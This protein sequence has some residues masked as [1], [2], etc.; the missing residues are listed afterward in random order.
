MSLLKSSKRAKE[1]R[2]QDKN[3]AFRIK[4]EEEFELKKSIKRANMYLKRLEVPSQFV[5]DERGDI[6]VGGSG[7]YD[8]FVYPILS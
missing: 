2:E 7:S 1:T 6:W 8:V 3:A 5:R 4:E